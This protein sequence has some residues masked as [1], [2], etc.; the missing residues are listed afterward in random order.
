MLQLAF[1]LYARARLFGGGRFSFRVSCG[2]P[3]TS[4]GALRMLYACAQDLSE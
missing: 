3:R 1:A 2:M 4:R